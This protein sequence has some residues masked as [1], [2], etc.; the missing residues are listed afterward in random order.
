MVSSSVELTTEFRRSGSQCSRLVMIV[1][2]ALRTV[3]LKNTKKNTST[4]VGRTW[5]SK[6]TVSNEPLNREDLS[7]LAQ[8]RNYFELSFTIPSGSFNSV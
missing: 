3:S 8:E 7:D 2:L 6:Q 5:S 1:Y 4:N